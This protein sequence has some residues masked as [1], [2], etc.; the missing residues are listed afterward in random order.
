MEKEHHGKESFV[1][2]N[3]TY[4]IRDRLKQGDEPEC[5]SCTSEETGTAE[6][7]PSKEFNFLRLQRMFAIWV[8]D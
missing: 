8:A 6:E 4:N 7:Y 1:Y 3:K 2:L 5:H